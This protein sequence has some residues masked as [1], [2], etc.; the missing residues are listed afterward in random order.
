MSNELQNWN[1]R[2]GN[3]CGELLSDSELADAIGWILTNN[4]ILFEFD[5]D[6]DETEIVIGDVRVKL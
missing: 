3:P 6:G 4:K 2:T 1:I 5:E